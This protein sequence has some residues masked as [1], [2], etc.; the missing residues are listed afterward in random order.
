MKEIRNFVMK[1]FKNCT[2][3]TRPKGCRKEYKACCLSCEFAVQCLYE[4]KANNDKVLP[5]T[6]EIIDF[7]EKCE[8]C[9]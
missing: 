3:K 1:D 2:A 9:F 8:F 7:N 4:A 5:C 6:L